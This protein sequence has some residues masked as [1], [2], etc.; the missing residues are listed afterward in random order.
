M[1]AA[2]KALSQGLVIASAPTQVSRITLSKN[3]I[4][5][6]SLIALTVTSA[7]SIITV[8]DDNRI[9]I[10]N[11]ASLQQTRDDFHTTYSQL[12]LEENTWASAG[13]VETI[14]QQNLGM[15]QPDLKQVVM[16]QP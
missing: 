9:A 8:A 1:N 13:R 6:L 5:I 14:A 11:L 3:L 10:G 2:A 15:L 16:I 4:I 7:L 12:L